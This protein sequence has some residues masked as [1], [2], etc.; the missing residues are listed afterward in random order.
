MVDRYISPGSKKNPEPSMK[1]KGQGHLLQMQRHIRKLVLDS[2]F[3]FIRYKFPEYGSAFF[4]AIIKKLL[5]FPQIKG[6]DFIIMGTLVRK[7]SQVLNL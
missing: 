1:A 4:L 3:A 6:I 7:V 2:G 5:F